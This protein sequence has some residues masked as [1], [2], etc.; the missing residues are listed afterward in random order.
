MGNDLCKE[1]FAILTSAPVDCPIAAMQMRRRC[2]PLLF[3]GRQ[4][5]VGLLSVVAGMHQ[6]RAV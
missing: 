1:R 4:G 5:Q 3:A 2:V 6:G